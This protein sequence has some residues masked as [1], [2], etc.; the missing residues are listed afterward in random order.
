MLKTQKIIKRVKRQKHLV[1]RVPA[2][3]KKKQLKP[4]IKDTE[5]WFNKSFDKWKGL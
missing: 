3:E 1:R 5:Y 2:S 4:K